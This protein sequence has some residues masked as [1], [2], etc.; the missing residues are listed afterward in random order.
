MS[1][2]L[3]ILGI[4]RGAVVCI[5][6]AGGKTTTMYR[7][8]HEAAARGLPVVTTTTTAIQRPT[9][10]QSPVCIVAAE[11]ENLLEAVQTTLLTA[12]HITVVGNRIRADKHGAVDDETLALLREE[13]DVLIVEADGARHNAIKAPAEHEPVVPPFTT[14]FLSVA[15]LHALGRPLGEVCHRPERASL[16][17]GLAPE[18]VVTAEAIATLLGA[19]KGGLKGRPP[20]ASAWAVLTHHAPATAAPA[21][22]IAHRLATAGYTGVIALSRSDS[23]HLA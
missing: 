15:G 6:G 18:C 4:S 9:P 19:A 1:D 14:C 7:L 2:A 11:V 3:D 17:T 12:Q 13:S 5:V 22:D 21:L 23:V 10:A 8:A 16:L 20:S